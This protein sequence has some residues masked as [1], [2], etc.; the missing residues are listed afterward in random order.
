MQEPVDRTLDLTPGHFELVLHDGAE[1]AGANCPHYFLN[2]AIKA[3]KDG[4]SRL[5]S[6]G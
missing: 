2:R 4:E 6:S 3:G 5:V 1:E